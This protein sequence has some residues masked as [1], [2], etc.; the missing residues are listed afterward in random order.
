MLTDLSA[1]ESHGQP[2]QV[3]QAK[4]ALYPYMDAFLLLEELKSKNAY[5]NNPR[6]QLA[7]TI[8]KHT[9]HGYVEYLVDKVS[10]LLHE[11]LGEKTEEKAQSLDSQN[12][13]GGIK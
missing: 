6:L 9:A 11:Q 7:Q 12:A 10:S 13:R 1:Q 5:Q 2:S 4:Q 8:V 3:Q